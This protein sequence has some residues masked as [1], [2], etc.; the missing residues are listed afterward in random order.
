MPFHFFK[1]VV[2]VLTGFGLRL[3]I[4]LGGIDSSPVRTFKTGKKAKMLPIKSHFAKPIFQKINLPKTEMPDDQF[5]DFTNLR[6][7]CFF[8]YNK[9]C[10]SG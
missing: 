7:T 3:W 6:S 10:S 8:D 5:F 9:V 1:K 2:G 4:A